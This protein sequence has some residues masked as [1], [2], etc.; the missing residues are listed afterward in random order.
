[1]KLCVNDHL[2]MWF[3]PL[4]FSGWEDLVGAPILPGPS[5]AN[6][7]DG[8]NKKRETINLCASSSENRFIIDHKC[9]T[10]MFN[11]A[12]L[13]GNL[14]IISAP[15]HIPYFSEKAHSASAG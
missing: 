15:P 2:S 6:S 13:E 3:V 14:E 8:W 4:L 11:T 5:F 9:S 12:H 7:V 10:Q 1:M